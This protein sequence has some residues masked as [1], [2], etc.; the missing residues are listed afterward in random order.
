[1]GRHFE[2][3]STTEML[4]LSTISTNY[5]LSLEKFEVTTSA[6]ANFS[7]SLQIIQLYRLMIPTS[8]LSVDDLLLLLDLDIRSIEFSRRQ[9]HAFTSVAATVLM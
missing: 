2:N 8:W 1:M 4:D 5:P 7:L 9:Q 6:S 3:T